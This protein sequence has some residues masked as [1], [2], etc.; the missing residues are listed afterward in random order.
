VASQYPGVKGWFFRRIINLMVAQGE[1]GQ[2]A[3]LM[4]TR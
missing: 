4:N 1:K 3:S 2:T